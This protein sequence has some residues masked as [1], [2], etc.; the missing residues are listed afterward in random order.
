MNKEQTD[1]SSQAS[2]RPAIRAALIASENTIFD[3]SIFLEHLLAGLVNESIPTA[4]ICPAGRET[5][6]VLPP[7][8]EVLTY[9]RFYFPMNWIHTKALIEQLDKFKPT[10][11]HCLCQS[12]A[13][14]TR[15][16][17]RKLSVPY[18]LTV[19]SLQKRRWQLSVSARRCVRITA[20]AE[21]I[22]ASLT[23]THPRFS[24]LIEQIN[25]GTFVADSA[26]CFNDPNRLA[27]LVLTHPMNNIDDFR[28]LLGAVRHLAVDGYE[29]LLILAGSGPAEKQ[30]RKL[31][32]SL[33]ISQ[34][35]VRIERLQ[36]IR[37]LLASGDIFIQ[38]VPTSAFNTLLLE[39]MSVGAAVAACRGGVD[40]LIIDGQTAIVF[41]PKDELSIYAVLQQLL[42]RQEVARK[43]A[44]GGQQHIKD[45]HT[46]SKMIET[47]QRIYQPTADL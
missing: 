37:S 5:D 18:V 29:F 28:N 33:G 9:P 14:F 24:E 17:S 13:G 2:A 42:D 46:V 36:P 43:L 44:C 7:T 10:I 23:K 30:L 31:I 39:A 1:S 34:I 40:D 38:P 35:I 19:N 12:K 11:L 41:D 3:Y 26:V 32:V 8:V 15:S 45:H 27:S 4:L 25:I 16:L 20:P 6:I 47:I 22:A 21:S